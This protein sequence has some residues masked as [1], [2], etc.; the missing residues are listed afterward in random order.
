METVMVFGTFDI[1]HLGHMNM[2]EQA[3]K[4]GS[5][6]TVVVARDKR[7]ETLK[8]RENVH[9]ENERRELVSHIDIV[10]EAVLGNHG[11]VYKIIKEKKPDIIALGYDQQ[12][13]VD[14]LE[15][16][17]K[18]FDL[19][20]TVVRLKEYMPKKHKSTHIRNLIESK[21]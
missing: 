5:H 2:F 6:L 18:E 9:N 3:K 7:S 8:K 12:H 14:G 13:F 16:K 11:D 4:H 21:I 20:T 1:L 10:D 17:I 19:K 15:N